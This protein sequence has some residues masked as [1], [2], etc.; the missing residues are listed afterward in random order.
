VLPIVPSVGKFTEIPSNLII[1]YES[2]RYLQQVA[3]REDDLGLRKKIIAYIQRD[4]SQ[5]GYTNLVLNLIDSI[6]GNV[7]L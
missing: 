5:K 2:S 3:D 6:G 7:G 1:N 4:H